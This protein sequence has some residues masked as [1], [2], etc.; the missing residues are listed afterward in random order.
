MFEFCVPTRSTGA[1]TGSDW[2]HEIKQ[3]G[4]RLRLEHARDHLRLIT[5]GG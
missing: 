2:L 4:S 3:D 5:R 1:P